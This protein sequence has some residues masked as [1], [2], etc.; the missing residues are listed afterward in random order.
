MVWRVI[1]MTF[2]FYVMS[3]NYERF[4]TAFATSNNE[5]L[6]RNFFK[7]LDE[8][9]ANNHYGFEYHLIDSVDSGCFDID[10][11][12]MGGI[13][14]EF[15]VQP[16]DFRI[17]NIDEVDCLKN[18]TTYQDVFKEFT[19]GELNWDD[20][21]FFQIEGIYFEHNSTGVNNWKCID[22]KILR[23]TYSITD[24]EITKKLVETDDLLELMECDCEMCS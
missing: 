17:G 9:E 22:G 20:V 15:Q 8:H 4:V 18:L 5:D 16:D 1:P 10:E 2:N 3:H 12:G 14:F 24:G 19:T 6:L 21:T 7:K 13:G 23:D 11:N